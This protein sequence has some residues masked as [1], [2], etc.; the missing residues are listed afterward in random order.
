[1]WQSILQPRV[2]M[3]TQWDSISKV[4]LVNTAQM[5]GMVISLVIRFGQLLILQVRKQAQK[6][7]G[8][9]LKIVLLASNQTKACSG[10][11]TSATGSL[12]FVDPQKNKHSCLSLVPGMESETNEPL[13]LWSLQ[14]LSRLCLLVRSSSSLSFRPQVPER[15]LSI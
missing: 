15:L 10:L 12:P 7:A 8:D 6:R 11:L 1:M 14:S 3:G 5:L 9:L 2:A 4:K 13:T